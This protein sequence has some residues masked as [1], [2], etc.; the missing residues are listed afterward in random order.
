MPTTTSSPGRVVLPGG[1]RARVVARGRSDRPLVALTFDA[2]A[3]TGNTARILDV[4]AAER[5]AATFGLTGRWVEANPAL[6]RRIAAEGHQLVNHTDDHSS[7]TGVSTHTGALS[8]ARR[9]EEVARAEQA[10][11]RVTGTGT[12]G[13]FRPP[14]GDR[15]AGVDADVGAAGYGVEL[16]WSVDSLG[17]AGHS[18]DD[19][20]NRVLA[21]AGPGMIA[22]FHVGAASAD[23]AALPRVISGLRSR[24]FGFGT[25]AQVVAG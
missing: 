18:V 25:A 21:S 24:G 2:G 16:M 11:Q 7:F 6:A 4:L 12:A 14:Y 9:S 20:V 1:P 15:D 10:I 13:W 8:Q 19:I 22:L 3:D 23:A 5:V 17:W